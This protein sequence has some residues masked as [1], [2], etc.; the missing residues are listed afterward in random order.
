[1]KIKILTMCAGTALLAAASGQ[2]QNL[3]VSS[4]QNDI[5]EITPGG[6]VSTFVNSITDPSQMAF[7]SSGDLFVE[8]EGSIVEITPGGV[9]STFATGVSYFYGGMAFNAAGDLFVA[10]ETGTITEITPTGAK[11]TFT[12]GLDDPRGL[13]FSGQG[14]LY[15]GTQTNI[16]VLNNI[17]TASTFA[18]VSGGINSLAFNS[19]GDLFAENGTN[20]IEFTPNGKAES[21]FA[22]IS[23]YAGQMA[24]NSAGNLF[25]A[26]NSNTGGYV[27]EFA[28][29]GAEST[30]ASILG[31]TDGLAFQPVPE[32]SVLG[33]LGVG[34]V[35]LFARARKIRS[36][37]TY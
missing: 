12:S 5:F 9:K 18:A 21:T 28:P 1:M 7:N 27:L 15:V 2:V 16:M 25:V 35:A 29:N 36:D 22:S 20:I 32:P 14:L 11:S 13:A 30:F 31:Q 6:T 4:L 3:F 19:T 24:F 17:G 26:A 23:S 34:A 10:D 37:A 33:L 8:S